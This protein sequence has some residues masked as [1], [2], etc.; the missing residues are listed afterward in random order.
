MNSALRAVSG[1][2]NLYPAYGAHYKNMISLREAWE[3]GKDFGFTAGGPY[4]SIRDIDALK[5]EAS[6]VW[7]MTHDLSLRVG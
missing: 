4:T 7:L 1:P 6:S 2:L 5:A 3:A